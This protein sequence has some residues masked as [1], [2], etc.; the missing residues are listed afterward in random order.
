ML[1][2]WPIRLLIA[3]LSVLAV[4]LLWMLARPASRVEVVLPARREVI[5]LVIASGSLQAV[6]QSDVGTEVPGIVNL[7]LVREGDE[8]SAG[9]EILTLERGDAEQKVEQARLAVETAGRE[10]EQ[11]EAGAT[12]EQIARARAQLAQ[13]RRVNSAQ[14]EE[15]SQR[16]KR[17]E[18]GGRPEERRRAKAALDQARTNRQ[19][20]ELDH[21]RAK[22]LF[23][24]GAIS[25][26]DLDR[27]TTQLELA[28]ASER[29]AE[30]QLALA[31]QPATTEEIAAARAEVQAAKANLEESVRIAQETLR[32]LLKEPRP[33]DVRIAQS[34]LREA[35]AALR[36]ARIEAEKRVI[37]APF[38]GI[39][40]QR[41][42]EPGQSVNPGMSLLVVAD[43]SR[44]EVTVETDETNLPKLRV[45]QPADLIAPA[46]SYSPFRGRVVKIG[47]E[48]DTQRGVV[49]VKIKPSSLPGYARPNMTVDANIEVAKIHDALSVPISSIQQEDQRSYVLV[50]ENGRAVRRDVR[51]LARG[52]D[53]AAV[54]GILPGAL[55]IERPGDIS[56]GQRVHAAGG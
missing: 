43:M 48:V 34:R 22:Q 13:A 26:A 18:A 21:G 39:V 50:V 51:V 20:A 45:G 35:R 42:M 12:A 41:D 14:L 10:L 29:A 11:V 38:D 6:R 28:R 36:E 54:D 56:S 49:K 33:E 31:E 4:I 19:Q 7:V 1:K 44:T 47:P 5:E 40:V 23:T 55:V 27:A 8:V 15:A 17:L 9:Q 3:G 46:Y 25:R 32:E 16:L 52:E 2:R 37:R 24:D 30:D 53:Y